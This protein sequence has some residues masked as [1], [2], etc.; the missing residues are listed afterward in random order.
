MRRCR[1]VVTD[2]LIVGLDVG[3][4]SAKAVV[5]TAAG[6]PVGIGS[7]VT[8]WF[9]TADGVETTAGHL[10]DCAVDA[11]AAALAPAPDGPV[12]GLGVTGMGESGIL[13]DR[14]GAPIGPVVAWHDT[15]DQH[16]I[17]ELQ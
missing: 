2:P 15:R 12:V 1:V 9:I 7:A 10:L 5:Y 4:S 3:T 11:L 14:R 8:P 16:D 13:L 17:E 6:R